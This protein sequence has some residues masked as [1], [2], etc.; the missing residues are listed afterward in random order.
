MGRAPVIDRD[1]VLDACETLVRTRGITA[2]TI[3]EVAKLAGI[4]KG[5]VQSSF[6]TKEQLVHAMFAR[7]DAEFE[8]EVAAL[9]GPDAAP[10]Q[11]LRA[12]VEATRRTDEGQADRAAALTTALLQAP[13]QRGAALTWYRQRL[14]L[15]D[16]ATEAGRRARLA[17]LAT[18]GAFLL[19]S[20]GFIEM[21]DAEWD[22]IFSDIHG[23]AG[24]APGPD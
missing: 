5:G 15:A 14:S 22:A 24:W 10:L 17:F 7:W 6:G 4:S 23:L 2:L 1:R 16:P 21:T 20:F 12:H 13:D 9:A 18:E 19:R 11:R 8:T 3:G